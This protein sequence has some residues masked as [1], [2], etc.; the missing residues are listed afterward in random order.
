MISVSIGQESGPGL[1]GFP[2]QG[3]TRLSSRGSHLKLEVLF[4]AHMVGGIGF[5]PAVEPVEACFFKTSKV[6]C[7]SSG[8]T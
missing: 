2:A 1:P 4:Q 7:L 8:K 5:L 6:K 3:L